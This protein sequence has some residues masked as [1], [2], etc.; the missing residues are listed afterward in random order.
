MAEWWT[1]RSM[2]AAVVMGFLKIR[3][4]SLKTKFE[5]RRMGAPLVALGHQGEEDLDLLGRLLDVPDVVKDQ[6]VEQVEFPEG[7]GQIEIP[8]GGQQLLDQA[9][10]GRQEDRVAAHDQRMAQSGGGVALAH[11]GEAEDED[12]CGLL[13]PGAGA[14]VLELLG[15]GA[16]HARPV[17]GIEGL[18]REQVGDAAETLDPPIDSLLGL[19]L[20]D[21]ED[22]GEGVFVARLQ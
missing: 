12:V 5:V 11:A 17:E 14:E 7:P 3:S 21:V 4:H 16:G 10:G 1:R 6:D 13:H 2:A 8:L 15:E 22:G 9:E 19:H 20:D 18:A